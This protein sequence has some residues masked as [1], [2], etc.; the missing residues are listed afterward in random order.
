MKKLEINLTLLP[1]E[2]LKITRLVGSDGL[3]IAWHPPLDDEVTGYLVSTDDIIKPYSSLILLCLA[4]LCWRSPGAEGSQ[5]Q[6]NQGSASNKTPSIVA[7]VVKVSVASAMSQL[8]GCG[9]CLGSVSS[10]H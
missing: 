4:D 7:Q 6:Q 3:L 2:Q 10:I 8:L 1:P 9:S 5:C